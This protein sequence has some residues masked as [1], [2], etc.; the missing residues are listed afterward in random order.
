MSSL[1]DRVSSLEDICAT[2]DNFDDYLGDFI[3]DCTQFVRLQKSHNELVIVHNKTV[4]QLNR[5]TEEHARLLARLDALE[6]QYQETRIQANMLERLFS[7][8]R[9]RD[10]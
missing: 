6:R 7:N 3:N 1:G 4:D 9:P 8:K 2:T 10:N 5:L